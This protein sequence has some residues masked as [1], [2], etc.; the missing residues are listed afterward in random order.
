MDKI[1]SLQSELDANNISEFRI[2]EY[3]VQEYTF[4]Q[5]DVKAPHR[6]YLKIVGSFD[7]GYYHEVEITFFDVRYISCPTFFRGGR[8]RFATADEVH[9]IDEN[10][11]NS[12]FFDPEDKV[13]CITIDESLYGNNAAKYF[14]IAE[15]FDYVF[16][17][18]LYYPREEEK[19]E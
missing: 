5:F 8:F 4:G 10:S 11:N 12:F 7:F 9:L 15:N 16:E 19:L 17:D 18:V 6:F 14:I 1:S 3:N 2:F 13:I